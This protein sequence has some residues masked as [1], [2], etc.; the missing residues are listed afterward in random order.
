M[1]EVCPWRCGIGGVAKEIE[2]GCGMEVWQRRG[3]CGMEVW[4]RRGGCRIGGVAK[5]RRVWNRRCGKGE[6]GVK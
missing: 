2:S 3:W 6:E 4:Q 5:E 1:Q